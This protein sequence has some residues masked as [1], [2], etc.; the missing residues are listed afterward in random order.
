MHHQSKFVAI[1]ALA[2]AGSGSFVLHAIERNAA[3]SQSRIKESVGYLASDE[4]EGRGVGTEGLN[5]AADYLAGEFKKLGLKTE[6]F[7]GTPFQKFEVTVSTD[8]GPKDQN[9]LTLV[10]P[11][12]LKLKLGEDFTP[13]AVGG[14]AKFDTNLVFVGYG[15]SAKDLNYDDYEGLD[16]KDKV[17]VIIRKEP[18]Q[19]DPKSKFDGE[20]PSRHAPFMQKISN[21]NGHGA[22]AVIFVNDGLELQSAREQVAK[23]TKEAQDKLVEEN[24][25]FVELKEPTEEQ[26]AKHEE[27]VKKLNDRLSELAK[28]AE[29]DPDQV[30]PFQGAGPDSQQRKMPVFFV[31]RAIIDSVV[32]K[33]LGKSL[34]EIEASIDADLKPQSAALTGWKADGE[35]SVLQKKA[36]VKNVIAVLEGEGPHAD[37]TIVIGAHYDHVGFG[38]QGSGSLAPWTHEVHNGADDNASGTATL[39]EV[40]RLLA[41]SGKKPQRRIVFMAFTGE[42]RGLLG[43]AHYTKQ[44]RFPLDNT[45]AMFNLDMVGRLDQNKL[46]VY[47]TGTAKEFDP[48][49]DELG[50]KY[51]FKI[52]K[53]EGGFGPSDHSSFYAKKIPVLHLFTGTH[54]D[55]H[56]PSDDSPKLNIEGMQRIA[57]FLLDVVNK[58][59][60]AEARPTYIKNDKQEGI[61]SSTSGG[62]EGERPY[63]GSIP[64]FA[65]N[66]EGL[67]ITGVSPGSPA[68]KAG[69]KGGDIIIKL[70][71]SKISGIEDL[72]SS[73]FKYKIGETIKVIVKRDGK[74]VTLE[75]TLAKRMR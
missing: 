22:A 63:L 32:K 33:S 36:E 40:A 73:L 24:K 62:P 58:T 14:S 75:V 9:F 66:D 64:D 51:E 29:K 12:Q 27:A 11:E 71:E 15:I 18:Q 3:D 48:L 61:A 2:I 50:K 26:K 37:E 74:E 6:L 53:H 68:E 13:L 67:A 52:T 4:L 72:Q 35:A 55:Y 10:G 19:K 23:I 54:S 28:E 46:I 31:K 21:A 8:L 45:I 65:A 47:G 34:D 25:K 38:G 49:V 69:M 44:P 16:V 43:S 41:T 70:G 57:D 60:S 20:R 59:D 17:V 39:L 1:V 30:L 42:E 56:R 5:K 7:D